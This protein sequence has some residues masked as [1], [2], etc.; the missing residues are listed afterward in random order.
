MKIKSIERICMLLLVLALSACDSGDDVESVNSEPLND[1]DCASRP[2]EIPLEEARVRIV[3]TW[4]YTSSDSSCTSTFIFSEP[5]ADAE[6]G[7]PAPYSSIEGLEDTSGLYGVVEP[8][9]GSGL[10]IRRQVLTDNEMP[11]CSG[12]NEDDSNRGFITKL[13]FPST[14]TITFTELTPPFECRT[15]IRN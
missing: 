10:E 6:P 4:S 9:D 13:G 8:E 15:Y 14:E 1:D 12:N 7:T 11:N 2:A 3:G 5:D